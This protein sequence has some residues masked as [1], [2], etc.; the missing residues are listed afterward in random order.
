MK[1]KIAVLHAQIPFMF[2]GA[3]L[4]VKNLTNELNNR[5]YNA[6]IVSVPFKCYPE[7]VLYDNMLTWRMIDLTESNGEKIDLVISTKFPTYGISHPNHICWMVHQF[8]ECYDLYNH[9]YGAKHWQNGEIIKQKVKE[10]D[11]ICLSGCKKIYSIS[12][13]VTKR[14]NYYNGI[15]AQ[16]LYHPPKLADRYYSNEYGNYICS[17]GRL[18]LTKRNELLIKSLVHCNANIRAKIAGHGPQM[19]CLQKLARDLGVQDRVEFLGF[20]PDEKLPDLY[21]NAFAVFFAPIDEDYGYITLEAFLSKKPVITCVDSGGP[22]EFIEDSK[23]GYIC[24]PVPEELG[25]KMN[26]LFNDRE[27]CKILGERG[28]EVVQN[29][30]WDNVITELTSTII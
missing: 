26:V 28:K 21:S 22:L 9:E 7:N 5:G 6:E 24:N 18:A 29:I 17:V 19:D 4:L 16:T 13:N 15:H 30:S 12:D 25:D 2:D 27:Y 8:R 20:V 3:E 10:F 23:N 14:L 11:E 1:K